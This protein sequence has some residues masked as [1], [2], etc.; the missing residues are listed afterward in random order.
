MLRKSPDVFPSVS[1]YPADLSALILNAD[2]PESL[3]VGMTRVPYE[4]EVPESLI[5][6]SVLITDCGI[7][8]VKRRPLL[9]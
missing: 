1:L 4:S 2:T 6:L 8:D 5:V 3:D 9:Y 7:T